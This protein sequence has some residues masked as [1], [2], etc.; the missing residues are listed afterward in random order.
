MNL[1]YLVSGIG[2]LTFLALASVALIIMAT[3]KP[4]V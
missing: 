1:C 2:V 4:E 3:R